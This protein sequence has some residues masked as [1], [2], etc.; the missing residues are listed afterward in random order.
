METLK[1][2][3]AWLKANW[4][5]LLFP[6]GIALFIIGRLSSGSRTTTIDPTAAADERAKVEKD[7]RERELQE[8]RDRLR[9]RLAEVHREH[10][11]KLQQLTDDQ[12]GR[13]AELEGD[14]EALN[15]WLRSL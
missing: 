12:M 4:K 7:R 3:W 10:Q 11:A 5:W 14:P 2:I 1:K 8:E 13:A 15:A 6:V 9:E